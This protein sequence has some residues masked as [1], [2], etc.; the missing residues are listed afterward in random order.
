MRYIVAVLVLSF[1]ALCCNILAPIS[2][3]GSA[4]SEIPLAIISNET[5]K[6][7]TATSSDGEQY[8]PLNL[9]VGSSFERD[10]HINLVGGVE[11]PSDYW[12]ESVQVTMDLYDA[13]GEL[14]RSSAKRHCEKS[15]RVHGVHFTSAIASSILT[16]ARLS[17]STSC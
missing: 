10:K 16:Q 9:I 17:I 7:L 1:T 11:N 8:K 6:D 12:A 3:W 2:Q 13:Q 14:L 5:Q 15:L 4:F